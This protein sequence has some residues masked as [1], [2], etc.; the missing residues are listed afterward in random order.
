MGGLE[1]DPRIGVLVDQNA[2]HG[3][4]LIQPR[5]IPKIILASGF[6]IGTWQ[7]LRQ[8]WGNP[9]L[10]SSS[11]LEVGS[12]ISWIPDPLQSMFMHTLGKI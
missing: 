9:C 6:L 4:G 12:A 10:S 5:K 2:G 7:L 8:S 3:H 1:I 11:E